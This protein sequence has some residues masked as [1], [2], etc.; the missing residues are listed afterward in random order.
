MPHRPLPLVPCPLHDVRVAALPCLPQ[1]TR[2]AAEQCLLRGPVLRWTDRRLGECRRPP[3]LAPG[4]Q[5]A[6]AT[7]P[8]RLPQRQGGEVSTVTGGEGPQLRAAQGLSVL[9]EG[10]E[11]TAAGGEDAPGVTVEAA[12]QRP[13][14]P[15]GRADQRRRTT[16]VAAGRDEQPV[17]LVRVLRRCQ[18][19]G[20][21]QRERSIVGSEGHEPFGQL[22]REPGQPLATVTAGDPGPERDQ[23]RPVHPPRA[24]L[25]TQHGPG[26][27]GAGQGAVRVP[28][29]ERRVGPVEEQLR[30]AQGWDGGHP[31]G[32]VDDRDRLRGETRREVRLAPV[33]GQL[34]PEDLVRGV[35]ARCVVVQLQGPRQVPPGVG[36]DASV[37]ERHHR[38]QLLPRLAEQRLGRSRVQLGPARSAFQEVDA[39]AVVQRSGVPDRV[40]GRT[41]AGDRTAHVLQGLGIAAD[42]GEDVRAPQQHPGTRRPAAGV[43]RSVELGQPCP[44]ASH[45][46]QGHTQRGSH[47]GDPILVTVRVRLT[48]GRP[49]LTERLDR[50][51]AVAEH[52][53]RRLV[54]EGP[55]ARVVLVGEESSRR[56]ERLC[57]PGQ[58]ERRQFF[59]LH[60]DPLSRIPMPIR[61]REPASPVLKV[62]ESH[63]PSR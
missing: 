34:R 49:Q 15:P 1:P 39:G 25:S 41:G 28:V 8:H 30:P 57:R 56:C 44:G 2:Q 33:H 13:T 4:E 20:Q 29:G 38:L 59:S 60:D 51:T 11:A 54:G 18:P 45:H 61:Y 5:P 32:V 23:V 9:V 10:V 12:V 40:P 42:S 14:Q 7:G 52:D 17:R 58:C 26:L 43:H 63:G 50:L 62:G 37:V 22:H 21:Q 46:R 48:C 36:G 6:G 35:A 27:P 47:V 16:P 3:A 31:Q 24:P 53:A 19:T 55:V